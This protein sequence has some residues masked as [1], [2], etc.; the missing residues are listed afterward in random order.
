MTLIH[1]QN[2]I[3]GTLQ[4]VAATFESFDPYTGKPWAAIP[5]DG[6]EQVDVAVHRFGRARSV[7][8]WVSLA[9]DRRARREQR[10]SDA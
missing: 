2:T 3:A 5:L 8:P 4:P 10:S 1:F 7:G 6:R 9:G